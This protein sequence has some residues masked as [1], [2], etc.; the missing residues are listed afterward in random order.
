MALDV[1]TF[2]IV[3]KNNVATLLVDLNDTDG[4]SGTL[5]TGVT[6]FVKELRLGNSPLQGEHIS[7][8]GGIGGISVDVRDQLVQMA[9]NQVLLNQEA[10]PYDDLRTA[11]RKIVR[12]LREGHLIKI[13]FS[14]SA[15]TQYVRLEPSIS[16]GALFS[17]PEDLFRGLTSGAYPGGIPI[18]VW[19]Q[20][21]IELVSANL[22]S[23]AA[24]NNGNL[25]GD[26]TVDNATANMRS[27]AKVAIKVASATAEVAQVILGTRSGSTGELAELDDLYQFTPT[28]PAGITTAWGLIWSKVITP[29][30]PLALA[31]RYRVFCAV[32]PDAAV[33][34][35]FLLRWASADI[36]PAAHF[37]EDIV[38]DLSDYGGG[39]SEFA[40][41][42][43]TDPRGTGLDFPATAEK[44]RLEMWA[45]VESA[46]SATW[47]Q[48]TLVPADERFC[49][50]RSPGL[51]GEFARLGIRGDEMTLSGATTNDDGVATLDAL[52]EY[53]ETAAETLTAGIYIWQFLGKVRNKDKTRVK[54]GEFQII[55]GASTVVATVD[56]YAKKGRIFTSYGTK[57]VKRIVFKA[58]GAATYKAKAIYT[59]A[60][61]TKLDIRVRKIVRSF[62]PIVGNNR[63]FILD[64]QNRTAYIADTAG[65]RLW[66]ADVQGGIPDF[67][68][69]KSLIVA[70]LGDAATAA[71]FIDADDRGPLTMAVPARAGTVT[72]D[73]IPYGTH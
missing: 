19:R 28:T 43:M 41:V 23:A 39:F 7:A 73:V 14:G 51:V 10:T 68:P 32:K 47:D 20:P 44:L 24:I 38:L 48:V 3:D 13:T 67:A 72:V 49:I 31:G 66:P 40:D 16:G 8:P 59:A 45:R 53:A 57:R 69:D 2:E 70:R 62:I 6:S 22:A 33:V 64:G 11:I 61:S 5:P 37:A 63:Q 58:T 29:T 18:E 4:T 21:Q 60:T 50:V 25:A 55:E 52:N 36:Q 17:D 15:V 46:G 71:R 1:G 65:K 54:V 12:R 42:E 35:H 9:W 30:D 34:Y 56:L 26:V 27:P